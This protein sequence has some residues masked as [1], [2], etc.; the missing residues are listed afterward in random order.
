MALAG[1]CFQNARL[2][3][4]IR[5]RLEALA[6]HVLVPKQLGPNDG[7]VSYGQAAVAVAQLRRERGL[8][9]S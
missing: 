4:S 7:A 1:G 9:E 2:L 8:G 5:T 3:V 6:L